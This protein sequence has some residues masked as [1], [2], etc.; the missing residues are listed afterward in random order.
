[1]TSSKKR[2]RPVTTAKRSVCDWSDDDDSNNGSTNKG[3]QSSIR[4]FYVQKQSNAFISKNKTKIQN[5]RTTATPSSPPTPAVRTSSATTTNCTIE[6]PPTSSK[7]TPTNYETPAVSPPTI[8]KA[9]KTAT[10]AKPKPKLAQV[11]LDCGQ[12]NWG[13]VLCDKCGML[14]VPG[15]EEDT[16]Q[17]NSICRSIVLG[18]SWRQGGRVLE[19]TGEDRIVCLQTKQA[20]RHSETLTTLFQIV[21][22]DLG[23]PDYTP[24]KSQS[25]HRPYILLYVRDQRVVGV[26]TVETISQAYRMR[27]LYERE[28]TPIKAMLGVAVLWTHPKVRHQG[29]ATKLVT[30]ARTHLVFGMV[31]PKSKIAFSSPTEAGWAFGTQYCSTQQQKTMPLVYEYNT[32][33]T[34]KKTRC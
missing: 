7:T 23:M 6:T 21:S 1:M 11:F 26:I 13:Q 31:V 9:P 28:D 10:A 24:W 2:Q 15:V 17:H 29:I 32:Q 33:A 20:Q 22:N 14:Y 25:K 3:I 34:D 4:S 16:K 8:K 27:N 19:T 30:A 18:V 5:K 12:K